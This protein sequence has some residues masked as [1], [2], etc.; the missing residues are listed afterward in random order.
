MPGLRV[1]PT[2]RALGAVAA[3]LLVATLPPRGSRLLDLLLASIAALVLLG[4]LLAATALRRLRF[5]R[6]LP[7]T[8]TRGESVPLGA[9]LVNGSSSPAFSVLVEETGLRHAGPVSF[10]PAVPAAGRAEARA[11]LRLGERG[12]LLLAGARL[13]ATDPLGLFRATRVQELPGEILVHPRPRRLA[14]R[15]LLEAARRGHAATP[16]GARQRAGSEP[17][18]VREYRPGD[19]PR[20]VHWRLSARRGQLVVKTFAEEQ[21]E[22]ALIVLDRAPPDFTPRG[23]AA[24]ERAVSLAAGLGLEVLDRGGE[25]T[26]VSPGE[27]PLHLER[28]RG[29][30]G[31]SRLLGT[32][33]LVQPT[34]GPR[35][36]VPLLE[37]R[38]RR[39]GATA[40][41]LV[42]LVT[43][44]DPGPPSSGVRR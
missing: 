22:D 40:P 24:F 6:E 2:R 17:A 12:R 10:F 21:R 20:H 41:P 13:A 5:E 26:L 15:R 39:P 35:P 9:A 34:K 44:R 27:P 33:A 3:F 25:V 29:R 38:A 30:G 42:A 7:E 43:A 11:R 8:G 31:R 32:L 36:A 37:E 4:L 19:S 16:R 1:T 18:F 14:A 28:L 23:L